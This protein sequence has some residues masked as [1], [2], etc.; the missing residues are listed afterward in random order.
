MIGDL[1][2]NKL[3]ALLPNVGMLWRIC[4]VAGAKHSRK[5]HVLVF[6]KNGIFCLIRSQYVYHSSTLIII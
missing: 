5:I 3:Q 4:S 6:R 1:V 2:K